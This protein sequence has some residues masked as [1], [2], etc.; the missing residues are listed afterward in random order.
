MQNEDLITRLR[1]KAPFL[2][3]RLLAGGAEARPTS[4]PLSPDQVP[5]RYPN[6]G[7]PNS[8]VRGT[9]EAN[10]GIIDAIDRERQPGGVLER[11]SRTAHS[12][13]QEQDNSKWGPW[14]E[15]RDDGTP[16]MQI[17]IPA[18][19][20]PNVRGLF[21]APVSEPVVE[22]LERMGT[23]MVFPK[24][25]ISA[26][27][28][29][30][31]DPV[32]KRDGEMPEQTLRRVN[33]GREIM[34]QPEKYGTRTYLEN[35]PLGDG[36]PERAAPIV[37][38]R[39]A[40][41]ALEPAAAVNPIDVPLIRRPDQQQQPAILPGQ[42]LITR[43]R[44]VSDT[45]A[46]PVEQ[47]SEPGLILRPRRV[48]LERSISEFPVDA[49]ASVPGHEP[50]G[51]SGDPFGSNRIRRTQPRD[52]IADDAAYLRELEASP[53]KEM[54]R[55]KAM[56]IRALLGLVSGG[57]P[58][59]VGGLV[60]EGL[61]RRY[62]LSRGYER[63]E[64]AR[65]QLARTIATEQ[66][67]AQIRGYN[68][69]AYDKLNKAPEGSTRIVGEDEYPGVPAGTEIRQTWN[70]SEF[71][72]AIGRDR[73]PVVSKTTP[74]EK[75][76]ARE[77]KYNHK[78]EAVLVPK[79]GGPATPIFNVDGTPLTKAQNES[80]NVQVGV[81]LAPDGITQIQIER[82]PQTSEWVD[83]VGRDKKPIVR[84]TVGKIDPVT[85]APIAALIT[86]NRVTAKETRENQRK[87]QS[88][89]T[90][91]AEWSGKEAT[92]RKN[93]TAE[94]GEIKAKTDRLQVLYQEIPGGTFSNRGG[95][96]QQAI[97]TEKARLQKEIE[98]HRSNA[99]HFQTE[100]DK[101]ANQATEAR[102]NTNLYRDSGSGS[103]GAMGR[104]PARDGKHHY[105]PAEIRA[106]A[107]SAGVSYE[108]LYQTLKNNKR[109]VID[110]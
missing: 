93:K 14:H 18:L 31:F 3:D 75:V 10:K 76:A 92:F 86:D 22:P 80:G 8:M 74:A 16:M 9:Y 101:A 103:G 107:E 55:T 110:E 51:S 62:A 49:N 33:T 83:S 44:R 46:A 57:I 82:D 70:G 96:T 87:R 32:D 72:D 88:Y 36:L 20:N 25:Q 4:L 29:Y 48:N 97:D 27:R 24:G 81:R 15:R 66:Q 105:T 45:Q 23:S 37:P 95:R 102:R 19:E 38:L 11:A 6:P 54:G 64:K 108:S 59:A 26:G 63:V 61:T 39:R 50:F 79:D 30:E 77:I 1:R 7:G 89:E 2:V 94:D 35:Y 109:V 73:K 106:Q 5:S 85:G 12:D 98:T 47:Q 53:P 21:R 65:Q 71:V 40:I 43:P 58:G 67:Q 28:A 17:G 41:Q 78:N 60:D 52:L 100:A 84:G 90:E 99:T 68:A 56:G 69:T 91:A 13:G 34:G 42:E 104:P